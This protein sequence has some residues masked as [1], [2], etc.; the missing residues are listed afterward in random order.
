M[1]HAE[2]HTLDRAEMIAAAATR[3]ETE[4]VALLCD[5]IAAGRDGRAGIDRLVAGRMAA[6]GCAVETFDYSP[7]AVPMV[8]EF[9]NRPPES[10]G[11]MESCTIGRIG[12]AKTGSDGGRSLILFAHP[13]TE[14]FRDV[15]AWLGDPFAPVVADGRLTGWGVAD[16]LA[17]VAIMLQ[18]IAV[19]AAAGLRGAAP[20]A[21]V[22]AASKNHARGIGAALHRGLDADA[23]IYL[24]PAESGR[25]LEEIKAFAPG[26]VEFRI[27][28]AGRAPDTREPAHTAFA[29]RGVNPFVEMTH[30]VEALRALDATRGGRVRHPRLDA[31]IGRSTNILIS[32]CNYG[33]AGGSPR[34]GTDCA[35]SCAM[36]L[37]PGERL[38]AAMAEVSDAVA[39]VAGRSGWLREHPPRIDWLAGVSA[40]ETPDEAAIYRAVA[41][42]IIAAGSD[43][44]VNPLHT[45][46]DIRNP[47]VQKG[48]PTVGY[49]PLCGGLTMAGGSDEWVDVADYLRT[50]R[51][52]ARV[53]ATWCGFR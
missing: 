36:S 42:E 14:E 24:H 32:H 45:S 22:S 17:G 29:H 12:P 8:D 37:V 52:T 13:D 43:P 20:V 1:D 40:A 49:G 50:V 46:S 21:L 34:I 35:I 4:S 11:E 47:I 7:D 39:G 30:I 5:L 10:G 31:A 48:I 6:I 26:Q 3:L 53:V 38:D 23:A 41:D 2:P 25:G 16:D 18:G 9:V 28:V 33:A 44:V 27:A 51:V 19:L 15:P